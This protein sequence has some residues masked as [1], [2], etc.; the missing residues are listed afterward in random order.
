MKFNHKT[1]SIEYCVQHEYEEQAEAVAEESGVANV[2]KVICDK[3]WK[4]VYLRARI[5]MPGSAALRN[6]FNIN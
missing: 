5:M 1:D 2:Q 6:F 4:I 3:C